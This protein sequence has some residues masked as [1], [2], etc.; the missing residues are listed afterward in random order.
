MSVRFKYIMIMHV[1]L[2]KCLP[3]CDSNYHF[4]IFIY[5]QHLLQKHGRIY[6]M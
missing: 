6:T 3:Y 2:N 5:N 1:K 4:F